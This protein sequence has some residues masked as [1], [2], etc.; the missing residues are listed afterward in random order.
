MP[1][2]AEADRNH[3]NETT[4]KDQAAANTEELSREREA[5]KRERA[6]EKEREKQLAARLYNVRGSAGLGRSEEQLEKDALRYQEVRRSRDC[7][8]HN[9]SVLDPTF[10]IHSQ[11]D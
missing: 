9:F 2:N 5:R 10:L 4:E 7:S 11:C 1:Q 3:E 6:R 8:C